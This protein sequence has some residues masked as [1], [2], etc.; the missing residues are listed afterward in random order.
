[1]SPRVSG[2][3]GC[4][5]SAPAVDRTRARRVGMQDVPL[6]CHYTHSYGTHSPLSLAANLKIWKKDYDRVVSLAKGAYQPT[7]APEVQAESL[8]IFVRVYHA[9]CKMDHTNKFYERPA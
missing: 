3:G 7:N 9:R 5:A 2:E 6:S 1:M 4:P 8:Y